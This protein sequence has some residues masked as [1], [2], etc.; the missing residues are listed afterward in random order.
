MGK[1]RFHDATSSKLLTGIVDL[2]IYGTLQFMAL[3]T[4]ATGITIRYSRVYFNT[5]GRNIVFV[6]TILILAGE[7]FM[8]GALGL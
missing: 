6:W 3:G 4:L 5:S 8:N 7:I 2:D 1:P